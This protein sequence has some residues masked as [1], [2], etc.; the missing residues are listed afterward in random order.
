[1]LQ[2]V[3]FTG[4]PQSQHLFARLYFQFSAANDWNE[5]QKNHWS[6]RLIPPSITLSISYLS[7]LPLA[8]AVHSPAVN[9]PSNYLPHP[10][11]VFIYL[12]SLLHTSISTCTSSS[13]H[14]SLQ[15][16]LLN[17]NYLATM[18]YLLPTSLLH[19]HTLYTDFSTVLLTVLLFIPRVFLCCYFLSHC[20]ALSW[21]GRSCKCKP[22]LNWPTWLNKGEKKHLHF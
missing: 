6:W 17:C 2:Q 14:I 19:L 22:V 13:A 16:K 12:F 10:H 4:H 5:L 21:P 8:A 20:F 9:S 18:A 11:I 7:S 1:M 15:C 3:Y